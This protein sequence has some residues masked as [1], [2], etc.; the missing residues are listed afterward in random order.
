M[1]VEQVLQ[2]LERQVEMP[3][4]ILVSDDGSGPATRDLVAQWQ[5]RLS[6]PVRHVWQPHEG[7]RKTLILNQ[8]VA[9][10]H[11]N[12]FT[13]YANGTENRAAVSSANLSTTSAASNGMIQFL[14]GIRAAL[15]YKKLMHLLPTD[16]FVSVYFIF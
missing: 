9:S 3:L 2:G 7:F 6:A 13:S 16:D 12:V 5:K 1:G 10:A 8:S 15:F 4:E 14:T 11:G